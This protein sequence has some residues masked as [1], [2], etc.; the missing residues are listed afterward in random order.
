[1]TVYAIAQGRVSDRQQFN[2]YL[3]KSG[4]TLAE[5]G[6]RLLAVDE[7]PA[8][9]EGEIDF[10]RTVIL[11]FDSTEHFQRWYDSAEYRAAR[12]LREMA[13]DG[14]FMLIQGLPA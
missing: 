3:E 14:R 10:P 8:M 12:K 9:I 13:A 2:R 5:H 6:A 7:T 1:M 4:P 11:E